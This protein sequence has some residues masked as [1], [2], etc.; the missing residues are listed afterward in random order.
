MPLLL[1]ACTSP[2]D[3]GGDADADD[4]ATGLAPNGDSGSEEDEDEDEDDDPNAD[5]DGDG[6]TD[7]DELAQ[8]TDPD[9]PDDHPYA[10]GW[11]I[12]AC[13]DDI[14]PTGDRVGDIANGWTRT[15]QLGEQISL[16]DFCDHAVLLVGAAFW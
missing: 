5:S 10:G 1:I 16:H 7:N 9:D 13:R 4:S 8:N 2:K 12:D 11:P 15:D 14:R 3:G 6:F